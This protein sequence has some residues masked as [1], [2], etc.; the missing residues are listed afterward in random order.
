MWGSGWIIT[1]NYDD[2][3]N[4]VE[5]IV[6]WVDPVSGT[7]ENLE[8]TI[9]T[10]SDNVNGIK[11][12]HNSESYLQFIQKGDRVEFVMN[13]KTFFPSFAEIHDLSGKSVKNLTTG[14]NEHEPRIEWDYS[15]R[16]GNRVSPGIYVLRLNDTLSPE[17]RR[18]YELGRN[19]NRQRNA[20]V[21]HGVYEIFVV[22][23]GTFAAH[24][25][26]SAK[27]NDSFTVTHDN[28]ASTSIEVILVGA[29]TAW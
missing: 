13:S 16:Q 19:R 8:R 17:Y 25:F 10:Y 4:L 26:V 15:N 3:G 7:A 14:A 21:D 22:P 12:K 27:A 23:L 28:G 5:V 18:E 29:A 2:A 1:Y 9:W 6:Q 24:P 20:R 11:R